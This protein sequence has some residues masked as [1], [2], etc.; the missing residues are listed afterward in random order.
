MSLDG[1]T[2]RCKQNIL[3]SFL[4]NNLI[5]WNHK[6]KPLDP[7]VFAYKTTPEVANLMSQDQEFLELASLDYVMKHRGIKI[8]LLHNRKI[9]TCFCIYQFP[10]Y[11]QYISMFV[12]SAF[13]EHLLYYT[14][15]LFIVGNFISFSLLYNQG[16]EE[17]TPLD[18]KV[19]FR[20]RTT[21]QIFFG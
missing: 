16:E 21:L 12:T 2:P 19:L 8:F 11:V 7:W 1:G 10:N 20:A 15:K 13:C 6:I 9:S 18:F 5:I 17:K 14:S 4:Y 3:P